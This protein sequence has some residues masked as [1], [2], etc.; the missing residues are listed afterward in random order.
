MNY[1]ITYNIFD[2]GEEVYDPELSGPEFPPAL[3]PLSRYGRPSL[4]ELHESSADSGEDSPLTDEEDEVTPRNRHTRRSRS[5]SLT[6][7]KTK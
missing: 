2:Q 3:K 6:K 1:I 5:I 4:D 7:A